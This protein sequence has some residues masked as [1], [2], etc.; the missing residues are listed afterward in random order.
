[1]Y[2][3]VIKYVILS[4]CSWAYERSI[5]KFS[6]FLNDY[7]LWRQQSIIQW[8]MGQQRIIQWQMGQ[9]RIIQWQMV[10][11]GQMGKIARG[12][13][14]GKNFAQAGGGIAPFAS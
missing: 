10:N 13:E 12:G 5:K 9:Q 2:A 1:M 8:Q 14:R 11:E 4:V 7:D 3:L 6:S